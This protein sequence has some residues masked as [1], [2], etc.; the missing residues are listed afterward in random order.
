VTH[1]QTLA[2]RCERRLRMEAGEL[3]AA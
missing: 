1:D 3:V 2:E